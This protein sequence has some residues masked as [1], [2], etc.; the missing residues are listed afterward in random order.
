MKQ[1][2]EKFLENNN[3][4]P[5]TNWHSLEIIHRDTA[6]EDSQ[7]LDQ[8]EDI[9]LRKNGLYVY[10]KNGIILYVD[11]GQPLFNRI[12]NHYISSY[13]EVSGDTNNKRWHRFFS[14]HQGKLRIYWKEMEGEETRQV[15]EKMLDYALKPQFNLFQ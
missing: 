8:I 15:I 4:L 3:F 6:P 10:E 14:S 11:K 12:R 9:V 7:K 2:I 1:K 5:M 13:Q